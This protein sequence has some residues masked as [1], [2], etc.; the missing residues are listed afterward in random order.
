MPPH[1]AHTRVPATVPIA[2]IQAPIASAH[3]NDQ[4]SSPVHAGTV[5]GTVSDGRELIVTNWTDKPIHWP[6]AH[7]LQPSA[8]AVI[9]DAADLNDVR[10]LFIC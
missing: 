1:L 10:K 8:Y 9:Q 4:Q 5:G 2:P 7:L 6:P 3:L